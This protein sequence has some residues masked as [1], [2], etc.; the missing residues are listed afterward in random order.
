MFSDML[1]T[2]E[3]SKCAVMELGIQRVRSVKSVGSRQK[4]RPSCPPAAKRL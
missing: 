3:G 2:S 4:H 1:S